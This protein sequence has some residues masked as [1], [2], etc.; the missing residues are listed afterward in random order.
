MYI[1][2]GAVLA[3]KRGDKVCD[4]RVCFLGPIEESGTGD[5]V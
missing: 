1:V 5:V 4:E 2:A 3:D